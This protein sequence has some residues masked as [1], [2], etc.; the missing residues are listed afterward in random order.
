MMGFLLGQVGVFSVNWTI[1]VF[2]V[3]TAAILLI[4]SIA[5]MVTFSGADGRKFSISLT[6]FLVLVVVSITTVS[7]THWINDHEVGLMEARVLQT[8]VYP[9]RTEGVASIP[10]NGSVSLVDA[11]SLGEVTILWSITEPEKLVGSYREIRSFNTNG[12]GESDTSTFRWWV[13]NKLL[14]VASK[15]RELLLP[16]EESSKL[17]EEFAREVDSI[18]GQYGLKTRIYVEKRFTIDLGESVAE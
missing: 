6:A 1:G 8:A 3:M 5:S 11:A 13:A 17:N 7:T 15:S 10:R 18:L 16:M 2:A 4:V 14:S 9:F 12:P